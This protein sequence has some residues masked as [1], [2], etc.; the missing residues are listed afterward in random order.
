M[1]TEKQT[2]VTRKTIKEWQTVY[3]K[4]VFFTKTPTESALEEIDE[5]MKGN[6]INI[7]RQFYLLQYQTIKRILQLIPNETKLDQLI[8][9]LKNCSEN[10]KESNGES[11]N[12]QL[13][14]QQNF[15]QRITAMYNNAKPN[16]SG[17]QQYENTD[18]GW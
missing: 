9:V 10:L 16:G 12:N 18:N 2:G 3:G 14:L 5:E 15:I 1:Q 13:N 17:N 4:E 8:A 6:D 7:I 11:E